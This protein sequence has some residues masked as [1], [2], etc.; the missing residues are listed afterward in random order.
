MRVDFLM[1]RNAKILLYISLVF[2]L[3]M[4]IYISPK[5]YRRLAGDNFSS[6]NGQSEYSMKRDQY[7]EVLAQDSN[8]IVFLGTSLTQNFELHEAFRNP[9]IQNRGINGD[10]TGGMRNRLGTLLAQ[11]PKKI[12][13][14]TGINDLGDRKLSQDAILSEFKLL[15]S[16]IQ[17]NSKDTRVYVNSIF[18][19][20]N[21]NK[22]MSGYFGAEINAEI[23]Q[24]NT[25]IEKLANKLDF[26]FIDI[27]GSFL[28]NNEM[29]P[30]LT[31]DG[32]HLS[33]KGY[34]LWADLLS[35]FVNEK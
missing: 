15:I 3:V 12:F 24:L 2:N 23:I 31:I 4:L 30:E 16:K 32:V 33:G 18:P 34:L 25:Q 26:T 28:E 9:H 6:T 8:A 11:K 17:T 7:F 21:L 10:W 13:I 19:V 14:E 20:S 5:I 27:H 1:K 29:K 35:P 22:G